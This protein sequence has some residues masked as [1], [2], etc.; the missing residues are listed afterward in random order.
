MNLETAARISISSFGFSLSR[1]V[2]ETCVIRHVTSAYIPDDKMRLFLCWCN[3]YSKV[4][5]ILLFLPLNR[6]TVKRNVLLSIHPLFHKLQ[7]ED[8]IFRSYV[9]FFS[10]SKVATSVFSQICSLKRNNTVLRGVGWGGVG[11]G[12]QTKQIFPA[13]NNDS[14]VWSV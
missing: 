6:T 7:I 5:F 8:F 11:R 12:G 1:D 4:M 3:T 2:R 14:N 10:P 13:V 9:D